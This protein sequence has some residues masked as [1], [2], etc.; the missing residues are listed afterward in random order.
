MTM[1]DDGNVIRMVM[2]NLDCMGGERGKGGKAGIATM[3]MML[4]NEMER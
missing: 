4:R 2:M 1:A 3:M